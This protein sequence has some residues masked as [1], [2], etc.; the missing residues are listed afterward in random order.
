[1]H[2]VKTKLLKG[3]PRATFHQ[4]ENV[5][6]NDILLSPMTPQNG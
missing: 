5:N 1:M 3:D 2:F 4:P 6:E